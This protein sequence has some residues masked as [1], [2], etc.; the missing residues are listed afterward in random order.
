MIGEN[1]WLAAHCTVLK[2][3]IIGDSAVCAAKT[4]ITGKIIPPNA[5]V[6][7]VPGKII[8]YKE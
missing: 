8:K 5:I 4:V 1:V 6:A 7:G 2:G 3:S